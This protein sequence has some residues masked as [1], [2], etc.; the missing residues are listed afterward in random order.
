MVVVT[1]MEFGVVTVVVVVLL[2]AVAAG[3]AEGTVTP[4]PAKRLQVFSWTRNAP[5]NCAARHNAN[6]GPNIR[7]IARHC[8]C[9]I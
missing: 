8:P 2:V 6:P 1:M 7:S 9:T 3:G 4:A 5:T